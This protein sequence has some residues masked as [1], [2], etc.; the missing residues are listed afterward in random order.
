MTDL[1]DTTPQDEAKQPDSK[2]DLPPAAQRALAE[3]AARR[4]AIDDA[5]KLPPE[6]HGRGGLEPVRY[7]DWEIKGIAADF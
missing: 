5:A 7:G 4:A 1:P 2:R 6:H 3:A